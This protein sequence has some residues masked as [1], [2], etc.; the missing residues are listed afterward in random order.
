MA[1]LHVLGD[2]HGPGEEK[3]A[4][5]LAAEL[6]SSWD[7]IAGRQVPHNM[8]A[9]DLDLVVVGENGVYVCEEKAWGPHVVVG[10]VGWYSNGEHRPNPGNQVVHATKVLAGRLREKVA[11][12]AGAQ[13]QLPR[14]VHPVVGHI[15]MSHDA[16]RLEGA[17][18]LGANVVVRLKDA[19]SVLVAEDAA[20]PP[21]MAPLRSS[22]MNYLVGLPQRRDAE[23]PPTIMMYHVLGKP[24]VQ[25]NTLTFPAQTPAGHPVMLYCVPVAGSENPAEAARL[26][27]RDH[28]ALDRLAAARRTWRV[29]QWFD[30]E[31][32]RVTPVI[33]ALDASSL[34]KLA[35]EKLPPHVEGRV[36]EQIGVAVVHDAFTA[37][38]E[39][40][41]AGILH[42]ALQLRTVEVTPANRVRFRDFSRSKLPRTQTIAPS[43]DEDHPSAAFQA[44]GTP[45]EF[46]TARDDVYSL[47]L[48]LTQW[49]RGDPSD[50]PDHA[51]AREWVQSYPAVGALLARCLSPRYDDRPDAAEA[52]DA[53]APQPM[54]MPKP[55]PPP[56]TPPV[57]PA[58][59]EPGALLAARYRIDRKLGEG[60][61]AV[62]WLAF[63]EK[64]GEPR[65]LKHMR[66]GRVD[67]A[68]VL[69]EYRHGNALRSSRCAR[70]YDVLDAPEPGV[71]V[72]EYI[73]GQTLVELTAGR[74]LDA[75]QFRR[76][77]V[78]VLRGLA[79]AHEQLVYHRDVSPTNI[80]VRD[81][82]SAALID[83]GLA[84]KAD[85]AQSAVGS[86]PFTAPEVW[87]RRHWTPAADIYSAC[88]SLLRVML[89]RYPYSGPGVEEREVLVPPTEAHF[90]RFGRALLTALYEGVAADPGTRPQDAATYAD[91][92]LRARD[93]SVR[94]GR[95]VVNPTV[96]ALRGLYR[97]SGI[98]NAGNRGMDDDFA[99]STYAQ[100][101]LDT[102]LLPAVVGGELDVVVLSGNP[103]DGK[104]SFLVQVGV[105]LDRRGA[106]T[107]R[108]DAAGWTKELDG[109]TFSA[110]YDASESHG[111]LS[112][113]DL[114]HAALTP[115]GGYAHTALLA[116]NDGR[117]AQFL[118][119]FGDRYQELAE[120]IDR[121]R[122]GEPAEGRIVLVDLKR[123]ALATPDRRAAGLGTDVLALFTADERWEDCENCTA[124][125][126]C[127][128]RDNAERLRTPGA[129]EAVSELLLTSHLRRRRRATMR[130]V[131]SAYGWLITGDLSCE[132]V[133][134]ENR[135]GQDP[136]AGS[137][138]RAP[139]L[140]F[141]ANTGD[142]LVEE[143]R[144]LDPARQ[145]APAAARAARSSRSLVPDLAA[146]TTESLGR[147][148]RSLYF[149]E[150]TAPGGRAE[151]RSYRY[152]EEYLEALDKPGSALP[153]VLLGLSRILAFPRFE[154][155]GL[156]L[157]D[158]TYDDPAVRAIVVV[159]ELPAS[160]FEL[161]AVGSGSGY[162]ESFA[163][164]L[165]LRHAR[166]QR[167]AIALDAAE[168]ILRAADG[169]VLG[170]T[171]S[172]ALRQEIEGFGQRLRL[173]PA[174]SVL[175]VDG[176]GNRLTAEA[177]D[178]R[179][180][181]RRQ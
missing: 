143:W 110:V 40:H 36:P 136:R 66:P 58:L 118:T 109:R 132:D 112:S 168:L 170:D 91:R 19:A 60:A 51:E 87:A 166:G 147:L 153:R 174:R 72:Q 15:V 61:W 116:A 134:A 2:W 125:D 46:L 73:P 113:D 140:A 82:G 64:L 56:V 77:A 76:I 13:R 123:R 130:D 47:A 24:S 65:T 98:G 59:L 5:R 37:L 154:G 144:E 43:L 158:R 55:I 11:G 17:A 122:A 167:L 151:V 173:E 86:P 146:V 129:R 105:A 54:P 71:L 181:G 34:G 31:G 90:A 103:G 92:I 159:K 99:R 14:G 18:E 135:S 39:V 41:S 53:T 152:Y 155:E 50:Q 157:R 85:A 142:Y 96:A 62:T 7:V 52:A 83:F 126:V 67:Y 104:T 120:E 164:R 33:V 156:G 177:V 79:D 150:W 75:E 178:G 32:Y 149:G 179:I 28:D 124:R 128:I 6:P 169:E 100:T 101:L 127:P 180:I 111:E 35:A 138:R 172:A 95:P 88:A 38:A 1:R 115:S 49:L 63:D 80:I 137:G 106:T 26:A 108:S 84:A 45:L 25:G 12:W 162:I 68:Q 48:C 74:D 114:I 175:V 165:E 69:D 93:T 119:D 23:F 78:D 42:R 81:D 97:R 70:P 102:A 44:P 21:T 148:K 57:S 29:Q 4:R 160:T 30:W 3:A 171:A 20:L 117:I 161:A 163:D 8:S 9:V 131:R 89:G 27:V 176:A 107:R 121:Q 139:D 133:H 145:A 16:L 10:E 22:L 141:A 94:S